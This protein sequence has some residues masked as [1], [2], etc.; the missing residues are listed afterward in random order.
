[1]KKIHFFF[2]NLEFFPQEKNIETYYSLII[3]I[4]I[5]IIFILVRFLKNKKRKK[6]KGWVVN[7]FHKVI[8]LTNPN[9]NYCSNFSG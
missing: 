1:M 6:K 3:I 5:I 8:M 2:Q 7:G 4:I 9:V